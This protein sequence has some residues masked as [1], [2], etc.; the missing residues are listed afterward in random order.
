MTPKKII[1]VDDKISYRNSLRNILTTIGNVEVIGEASN[2]ADFLE[3]LKK[4]KPDITFMDIEMP[5]MDGI[6]ATRRA[7][8]IYKDLIIIGISI[9]ANDTYVTNLIE[10]GARGYLLKMGDNLDLLKNIIE[11]PKAEIFFSDTLKEKM[12]QKSKQK[13]ILVVDDFDTNTIVIG[14]ALTQAGYR[15]LTAN[16]GEA[17]LKIALN[18]KETIELIVV[19]YNMPGMN[20]A[21]MTAQIKKIPKYRNTPAIILSSDESPEKRKLAKEA[22]AA[23]WMKKPFV[24]EKFLRIVAG[25]F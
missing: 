6:E 24:L 20:G 5:I 15:V 10:A 18:Q 4:M 8:A 16:S 17:G 7:M 14:S 11:H 3:L 25:V 2:G 21:E 13:T 22:G 19:D 12:Y 1:I 9:Y 23:G